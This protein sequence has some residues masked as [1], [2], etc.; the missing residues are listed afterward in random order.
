M[1]GGV[2]GGAIGGLLKT[3]TM[4]QAPGA[5]LT[6]AE[7]LAQQNVST[8]E[9]AT[10]AT[11]G[12]LF[13]YQFAGP[14]TIKANQSAMLPFLH[15][16]VAARKLL[17]YT[18]KDG[19]HPV[20]AAELSNNTGK[21]LD[22]GP[23][24]VYDSGAYAGEALF[25]TLKT[26]D[27]RLIGY[28]VDYGTRIT[29]AFD[30]HGQTIREIHVKNGLL[31]ARYAERQTRTYTIRNVDATPKVLIIQQEGIHQYSILSPQPA[32]ENRHRV[33]VRSESPRERKS[34][35]ESGAGAVDRLDDEP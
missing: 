23:I 20:N 4:A 30:S 19:E 31:E 15:D 35:V 8:V 32:E 27:K 9:G 7:Q 24:T 6:I 12:E 1:G 3:Q 17:I 18:E 16:K 13:E 25:E 26:G 33:P 22:G 11:L 2:I 28:A 29:T 14:I 10:G 5:G 34:V 21:T